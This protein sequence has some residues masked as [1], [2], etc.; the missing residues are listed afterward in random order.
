MVTVFTCLFFFS[1]LYIVQS[2][3]EEKISKILHIYQKVT[4]SEMLLSVDFTTLSEYLYLL[5]I[6]ALALKTLHLNAMLY[7]A[8]A[9][10][11]FYIPKDQMVWMLFYL[12]FFIFSSNL[13]IFLV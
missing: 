5:R 8:A 10:S 3:Y 1:F 11:D 2:K 6:A 7:L 4:L 9:V 12:F 13:I